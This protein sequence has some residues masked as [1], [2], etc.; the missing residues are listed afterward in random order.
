MT[1]RAS[2]GRTCARVITS[3]A[4]IMFCV[5]AAFG[6]FDERALRIMGVGL[7]AAVLV[8]ATVVRLVLVP[9][10]MEVIGEHNRWF[11]A[12]TTRR[13]TLKRNVT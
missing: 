10:A 12:M 6:T 7:A 1:S 4:T 11:P 3:A 8:D 5:F 9:A 13:L 2:S